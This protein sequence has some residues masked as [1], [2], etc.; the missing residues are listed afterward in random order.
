MPSFQSA[1]AVRDPYEPRR[2]NLYHPRAGRGGELEALNSIG[3]PP[4][5]TASSRGGLG[6]VQTVLARMVLTMP[7]IQ[8]AA[9]E[10][11][12]Y[13]PAHVHRQQTAGG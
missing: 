11:G 9:V 6:L 3:S 8:S 4:V 7:S 5:P 1:A 2:V 12:R 10:R 13:E